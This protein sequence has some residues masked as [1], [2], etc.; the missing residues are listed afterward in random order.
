EIAFTRGATEAL[1]CLIGGYNR[2]KP[3]DAVMYADLDYPSMQY[4]MNWLAERRGVQ[5]KRFTIPEPA[6]RA[7]VVDAYTAALEANPDVRLLLTTHVNNKTGLVTPIA[8]VT[9]LARRRGA[10]V[11]VDAAHSW[12]QLDVK[13][14]EIG[15]DLIGFNLH[16]WIGAPVGAGVLY[17]KKGRLADVDRMMADQD[18]PADS[19]LSRVH[20]GTAHFA[21][22][23]TVPAALDFHLAVGPAFKAAR[24]RYLRD[25]WVSAARDLPSIEVLTPDDPK[26]TAAITSFRVRGRTSGRETQQIVD[27]LRDRHRIMTVRRTGIARGDCIRVTPALYNSATDVDRL[28]AALKQL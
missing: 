9:A 28:I 27:E 1:Q 14:S 16:K 5:V 15:A 22:F 25:R 2:L 10:D 26:M 4:A 12:G 23:L 20:S 19:I 11:I 17:I 8:E 24:V 13:A 6:T 3:G 7:N 18:A 21:T